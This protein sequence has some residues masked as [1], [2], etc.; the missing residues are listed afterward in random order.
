MDLSQ[1]KENYKETADLLKNDEGDAD[2]LLSN[3]QI[4]I[5]EAFNEVY[6]EDEIEELE[7]LQKEFKVLYQK[8][9]PFPYNEE[10][11][12]DRMFPDRNDDDFDE[13]NMNFGGAAWND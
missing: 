5:E 7:G 2:E 13:D 9:H 3:L 6:L 1:L 4:N 12:L 10:D 11:E 8:F